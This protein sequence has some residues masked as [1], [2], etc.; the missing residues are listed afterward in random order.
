MQI[1]TGAGTVLLLASWA[2]IAAGARSPVWLLVG[3]I[4]LDLAHK[5]VLNSNQNFA[6][7]PEARNRINSAFSTAFSS[8][9]RWAPL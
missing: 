9:A 3:V 8:A 5:A 4:V 2:A 1:V 6:L 7:R